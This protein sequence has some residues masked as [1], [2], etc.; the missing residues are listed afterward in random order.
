M[1]ARLFNLF[2]WIRIMHA[3]DLRTEKGTVDPFI[4]NHTSILQCE[5]FFRTICPQIGS[6]TPQNYGGSQGNGGSRQVVVTVLK[7]YYFPP[8]F[9]FSKDSIS[10]GVCGTLAV[11]LPTDQKVTRARS[12]VSRAPFCGL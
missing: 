2:N 11:H 7:L 9:F 3:W 8:L 12:P 4:W 5:K 1:Q 10:H 6:L